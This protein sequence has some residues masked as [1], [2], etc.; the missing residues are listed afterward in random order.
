MDRTPVQSSNVA[1]VG[2]NKASKTLEVEFRTGR[3]Y[4]YSGVHANTARAFLA[5]PSKGKYVWR[6]LRGNYS[7]VRV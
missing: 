4:Q 7:Y 6:R 5:A 2:Y 1:S 3:V